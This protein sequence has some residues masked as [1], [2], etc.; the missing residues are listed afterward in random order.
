MLGGISQT[1]LRL[2]VPLW[3]R[4]EV[5]PQRTANGATIEVRT[6]ADGPVCVAW[7]AP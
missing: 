2:T 3:A 5:E 1:V 4:M 6:D 7:E